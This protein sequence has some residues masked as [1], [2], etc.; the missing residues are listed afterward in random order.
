MKPATSRHVPAEVRERVLE[1]AAYRCEYRAPDGTRCRSRTRLE[2]E[3]QR[4]FAIFQSH[5][6]RFL[7]AFC[8]GHNRLSAERVYGAEFIREKIEARRGQ[9]N[10]RGAPQPAGK[11]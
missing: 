7:R 2:I 4:P 6:E 10:S 9:R 8:A 1:R 11:T 5:D 3:H